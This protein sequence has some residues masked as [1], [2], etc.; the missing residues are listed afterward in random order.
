MAG[1]IIMCIISLICAGMFFGIGVYSGKTIKPM[2]FWSGSQIDASKITDVPRYNT[3]NSIMWKLYSLLY[4]GSAL[5][6]VFSP[7]VSAILIMIGCTLGLALL[8][9]AYDKIYKKYSVK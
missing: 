7:I 5:A 9:V 3:E 1:K 4:F 6:A 2:G 8:A